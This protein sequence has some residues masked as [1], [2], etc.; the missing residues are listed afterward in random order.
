MN[1]ELSLV[2]E[3]VADLDRT[4]RDAY[5]EANSVPVELRREV[6]S[7]LEYDQHTQGASLV[8]G[9]VA[10]AAAN[11]AQSSAHGLTPL[12]RSC[13]PY[14]LIR[15]LGRGGMGEVWLAER[16]DGEV[17][18]QAAIKFVN[19][20]VAGTRSFE[21]RFLRERQILASLSHPGIARILDAGHNPGDGLPYLVMEYVDGLPIHEYCDGLSLESTLRVFLEVCDAVSHLHRNLVIHRDLKPSNIMVDHTSRVKLL[22]FGIAKILDEAASDAAVTREVL[23]TPEYASPEQSQG[24]LTSTASDIYS[25]GAV[26]RKVAA[27]SSAST[28]AL[29]EDVDAICNRCLRE[30]PGERYGSVDELSFDIR[31]ALESRPVQAREGNRW[32][33]FRRFLRRNWALTT[34]V[35]AIIALLAGTVY[36]V[37]RERLLAEQRFAQLRR[38]AN[39]VFKLD[40]AL[41]GLPGSTKT[42]EEVVTASLAYLDGLDNDSLR[43]DPVLAFEVANGYSHIGKV[44]GS[45]RNANLGKFELARATIEK[46]LR[47]RELYL[48]KR[49][50]DLDA[51]V[52]ALDSAADLAALGDFLDNTPL[53]ESSSKLAQTYAQR[54]MALPGATVAHKEAIAAAL[55]NVGLANSNAGRLDDAAHYLDEAIPIAKQAAAWRVLLHANGTLATVRRRSGDLDAALS[56]STEAQDLMTRVKFPNDRARFQTEYARLTFRANLFGE[57]ET[58]NL[59]R[60]AEGIALHRQAL[61]LAE[62]WIAKDTNDAAPRDMVGKTSRTLGDMVRHSDMAEALRIYENG[63][64]TLAPVNTASAQR[65]RARLLAKMALP[66]RRL[67]RAPEAAQR[68]A[69]SEELL[70]KL[71]FY[72][73]SKDQFAPEVDTYMQCLAQQQFETGHPAQAKATYQQLMA[74]FEERKMLEHPTLS[75]ATS[76]SDLFGQMRKT[77]LALGDPASA[78]KMAARQRALWDEWSRKLPRNAYVERRRR[79]VME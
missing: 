53:V 50:N 76:L 15:L 60:R 49:P 12:P 25:L 46:S 10:D 4:A 29:R 43:D 21:Q 70:R 33:L 40:T 20:V 32:Y 18:L 42:R 79:E 27:I 61:A 57:D 69:S 2:F 7:L 59:D 38:L 6:E 13:G 28:A 14:H 78:A 23:L 16:V 35:A 39:T 64:R 52:G 68:L 22:D 71:G 58:I 65:D 51:I 56:L 74:W 3:A 8:G 11:W 77:Y 9:L 62:S 1:S 45:P 54:A 37:N 47:V 67:G 24:K 73:P 30:E 17:T 5:Y 34:A 75:D 55:V 66:L 72:P 44:Q 19:P 48:A 36:I 41:R 26:L 63:E 31:A